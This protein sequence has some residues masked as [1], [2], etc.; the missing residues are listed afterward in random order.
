MF[1]A[2][3]GL[4]LIA[5]LA[6]ASLITTAAVL[7]QVPPP[8][9]LAREIIGPYEITV[10]ARP[11][12]PTEGLGAPRIIV[13]VTAFPSGDPVT[14]AEIVI[15]MDR[16][17]GTFA[18]QAPLIQSPVDPQFY[19]ARVTLDE[20]GSWS[21]TVGIASPLGEES[22]NGFIQVRAGPSSGSIGTFFWLTMLGALALLAFLAWRSLRPKRQRE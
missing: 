3:G 18:G 17:D 13:G 6:L 22:V 19:E 7:A 15:A 4:A 1:T 20:P 12:L 10:T 2:S 5:A 14:D 21:W 9:G 16:P 8:D 11:L